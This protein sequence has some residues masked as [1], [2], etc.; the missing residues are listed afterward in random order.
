MN[1]RFIFSLVSHKG[2]ATML[3]CQL[4]VELIFIDIF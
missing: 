4:S 2:C 3:T 1:Q